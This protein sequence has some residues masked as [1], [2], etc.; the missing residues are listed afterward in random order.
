MNRVSYFC[1][2]FNM[3]KYEDIYVEHSLYHY[4]KDKAIE[5]ARYV[6]SNTLDI[7][8]NSLVLASVTTDFEV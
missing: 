5:L 8:A 7:D 2:K 1:V 3:L 4:D 6:I